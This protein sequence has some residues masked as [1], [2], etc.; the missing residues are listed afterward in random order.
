MDGALAEDVLVLAG[1][2]A[3]SV[4]VG[5]GA[6]VTARRL[7][8]R[9]GP[10]LALGAALTVMVGVVNVVA[11][12]LAMLLGDV[13]AVLVALT[14]SGAVAGG[15][16]IMA[17]RD[18]RK[19]LTQI[20]AAAARIATGDLASRVPMQGTT[21]LSRIGTAFNDMAEA[22]GR[23]QREKTA[24]EQSRRELVASVSHDLRT[25]VAALRS[26]IE[27]LIARVVHEPGE[28]RR[29]LDTMAQQ[30][31]SLSALIDDMFELARLQEGA[32]VLARQSVDI[33]E[34]VRETVEA[35]EPEAGTREL[36]LSCHLT[37]DLPPVRVDPARV[38]RVLANLLSNALEH[39]GRGGTVAVYARR[40]GDRVEVEVTDTGVG[41][42]AEELP[43]IFD[44]LFTRDPSRSRG[45]GL[46]LAISRAIVEAHGGVI[47]A[48]SRVGEGTQVIVTLPFED[49]V[50]PT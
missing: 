44:R 38:Q 17:A 6:F 47:A 20:E 23:S 12:D 24:L 22:M 35:Y 10:L 14:L 31:R 7:L 37:P 32:M 42:P 48:R 27:A 30:I 15:F 3:L 41:I 34:V 8:M 16:A 39:T 2:G 46:G 9:L 33:T 29:Y 4:A 19:D 13:V 49:D 36:T 40:R 5:F 45:T 28:V 11:L 18:I 25:P 21:D 26:L 1:A 50:T 43:R